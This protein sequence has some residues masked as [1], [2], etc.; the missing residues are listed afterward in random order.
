MCSSTS[1]SDSSAS[2]PGDVCGG[3]KRQR[4][5]IPGE[6]P[7]SRPNNC[8]YRHYRRLHGTST[9]ID[10]GSTIERSVRCPNR[11]GTVGQ[12]TAQHCCRRP[13]RLCVAVYMGVCAYAC[14]FVYARARVRTC[15]RVCMLGTF[16]KLKPL[17][18]MVCPLQTAMLSYVNAEVTGASQEK[19]I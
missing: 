12:S 17:I 11:G 19:S 7:H 3:L 10:T 2:S 14:T 1:K 16:P 15:A 5:S 18:V 8:L 6:P 13:V 9:G 4:R